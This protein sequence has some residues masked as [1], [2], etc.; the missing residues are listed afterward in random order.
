MTKCQL[1]ECEL[2]ANSPYKSCDSLHGLMVNV[3]KDV[4]RMIQDPNSKLS[5]MSYMDWKWHFEGNSPSLEQC[6]YYSNFV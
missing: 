2:E 4:M 5:K 6:E 1:L 3:A